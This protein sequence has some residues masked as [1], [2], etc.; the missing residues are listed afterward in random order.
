MGVA[1]FEAGDDE[2]E[3]CGDDAFGD[4]A[5]PVEDDEDDDDDGLLPNM[6]V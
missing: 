2:V 6:F 4:A 5:D 3:C 1:A